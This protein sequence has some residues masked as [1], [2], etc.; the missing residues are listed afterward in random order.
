MYLKCPI[1]KHW[2]VSNMK[3]LLLYYISCSEKTH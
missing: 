1:V 2:M 3:C